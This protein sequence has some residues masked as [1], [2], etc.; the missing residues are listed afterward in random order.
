MLRNVLFACLALTVSGAASAAG[1][2]A[3]PFA[4]KADPSNKPSVQRGARTFMN[5]CSGCHS[6][7]YLRYNRIGNDL[8]ISEDLLAANLMF[9]SEKVGDTIISA[10]PAAE[11][12]GWFGQTPPDLTLEAR[13][14]GAD[15]I[16]SYMKSFYVD[17]SRPTGVNNVVL[18]NASMPHVLWEL[19]GWQ[20]KKAEGEHKAEGEAKP[21]EGEKAEGH[22]EGHGAHNPFELVQPGTLT[23]EQ[24]D[25]FVGDL[26]NFMAY[27]AEPGRSIRV[28]IGGWTLFYLII[29]TGFAWLLKKE[30]WKDV[31]GHH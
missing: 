15:W 23:P 2:H 16:Y 8:G 10:I 9:T 29:F 25:A 11:A 1:G 14:R 24:Y 3:L 13:A 27:A 22:G 21:A 4:F 18:A 26:V 6:M 30:F 31:P 7:K 17:E 12:K 28:G 19:Q 20:V 5:Y